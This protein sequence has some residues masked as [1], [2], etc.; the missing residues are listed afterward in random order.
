MRNAEIKRDTL[1]TQI[2]VSIELDGTGKT[3]ISTGIG[4]FDHMLELFAFHGKFDLVVTA[5]GDT[6]IDD[7]HT[8]EDVGLA[9][10]QAF[11]AALGNKKGIE[12]YAFTLLAMDETLCRV[13]VDIS[14]RPVLVYNQSFEYQRLGT[15]EVQNVQ[16]FFK[17]FA[18]EARISLHVDTLYSSNDHHQCEAMFKGLGRVLRQAVKVTSSGTSSTKGVL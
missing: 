10:G 13:A 11:Q 2:N 1:E 6:H 8:V 4:F 7:H 5:N 17:S 3:S 18:T 15:M 9:L 14:N 16:E 12:R